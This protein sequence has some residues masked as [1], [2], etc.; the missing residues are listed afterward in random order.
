MT[1]DWDRVRRALNRVGA[2]VPPP[3]PPLVYEP[4]ARRVYT[5]LGLPELFAHAAAAGGM[6][7]ELVHVEGLANGVADHLRSAGLT[8]AAAADAP[9]L[10]KVGLVAAVAML[11]VDLTAAPG[12]ASALVTGCDAAVAETGSLVFRGG[13]PHGWTAA[14]VRVVVVEPRNLVPDLL[15]LLAVDP[16]E[17]TLVSGPAAVRVFVL[18]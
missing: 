17:M 6:A 3:P 10:R 8:R 1:G 15:D 5:D 16:G 2:T 7:A 14:A 9:L 13:V 18:H 4:T 12:G 11:G